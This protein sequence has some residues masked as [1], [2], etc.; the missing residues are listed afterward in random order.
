MVDDEISA[1]RVIMEE[2]TDYSLADLPP[3]FPETLMW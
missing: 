3:R 2:D 1:A